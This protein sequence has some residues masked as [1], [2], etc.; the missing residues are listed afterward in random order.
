MDLLVSIGGCDLVHESEEL[1]PAAAPGM[2]A[3]DLAGGDVEGGEQRRRSV[4]LVVVRLAGK[5][6]AVRQPEI[7]LG[8]LQG[9]D[10]RL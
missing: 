1:D 4:P 10:R 7:A 6:A 5:R 8:A 2:A 3:D 9:L